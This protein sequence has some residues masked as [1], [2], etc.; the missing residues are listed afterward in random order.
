[1]AESESTCWT[2]I[3]AAAAG[4]SESR[5]EFAHRYRPVVRAALASRWRNSACLQELD[6][7]VQDVFVECFK[8]GGILERVERG[9]PG[10]FRA[11]LY[12]VIRNVAFRF[13]TRR[14][15]A[16]EQQPPEGMDLNEVHGDEKSQSWTFDRAWAIALLREAGS[17]MEQRAQSAGAA[18]GRRV[19]LLRLRFQESLPIREIASRWRTDAA[20]LHHEYAKARQEFKATLLDVLAFHHPG[21]AAEIEHECT[22][23]LSILSQEG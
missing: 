4:T 12:G 10:G 19:E 22:N 15:R 9:R 7:A 21:S 6:D 8:Q 1:M 5:E 23:L 18:A 16:R 20:T 13:E 3:E 2:V 17:L 11:F 14:A